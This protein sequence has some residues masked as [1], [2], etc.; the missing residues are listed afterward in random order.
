[1]SFFTM[2]DFDFSNKRVLVR[3]DLDSPYDQDKKEIMTNL[4]LQEAAKTIKELSDRQAK[5]VVCGHQARPGKKSFVRLD[6]HGQILASIIKKDCVYIDSIHNIQAQDCI[7]SL[8]PGQILL[9]ENIR[10][11]SEEMLDLPIEEYLETHLV[12]DLEPLF[13]YYIQ[14]C[15]TAAHRKHTSMVGFKNIPQVVGRRMQIELEG[16]KKAAREAKRPYVM[17]LGG[18]KI[19]DYFDLIDKV[20]NEGSVDTI[21][22]GGFFGDLCLVAKGYDLGEKME[23]LNEKDSLAR[24]SLMD[25]LPRVKKYLEDYPNVFEVPEDVAVEVDGK[26]QEVG[27]ESLPQSFVMYDIGQKTAN[28][29]A[30]IIENAATIYVKGPVG[31]Y[32]NDEFSLGS[33]I[34]I[35]AVARSSAYSLLGGGDSLKMAEMFSDLD[36]FSHLGLAGGATLKLLAGKKLVAVE[37]LE[38]SYQNFKDLV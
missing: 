13:D 22:T 21:L 23:V 24:M 32:E 28:R 9:L 10:F 19:F 4:R 2:D 18:A 34:V 15:F 16:I 8:R 36:R 29:Y 35:E 5:V 3:A 38:R 7:N 6:R 11:S 12:K 27:V 37:E 25:L 31:M 33:K 1:M 20:L 30:K 26:R 17:I 14:N